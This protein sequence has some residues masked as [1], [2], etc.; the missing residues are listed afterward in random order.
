M[1]V[2]QRDATSHQVTLSSEMQKA[3]TSSVISRLYTACQEQSLQ[4]DKGI[5]GFLPLMKG[6]EAQSSH[7]LA[8][9]CID[10]LLLPPCLSPVEPSF[11]LVPNHEPVLISVSGNDKIQ[12]QPPVHVQP[13][14]TEKPGSL[15]CPLSAITVPSGEQGEKISASHSITTETSSK[16]RKMIK[17]L[18]CEEEASTGDSLFSPKRK[19]RR[20]C[21]PRAGA[22]SQ[23]AHREGTKNQ[24]NLSGCSVSLSSNNVLAK[25]RQMAF[26]SSNKLE[27]STIT[28]CQSK[29]TRR[30]WDL[31]TDKTRIRTPD[32]LNKIKEN[33]SNTNREHSSLLKPVV[34]TAKIAPQGRSTPKQK[35]GHPLKTVLIDDTI[36]EKNG[37]RGTSEQQIINILSKEERKGEKKRCGKRRRN[38]NEG[39]VIAVKKTLT[40]AMDDK[41][42]IIPAVGKTDTP[43]QAQAVNRIR[44]QHSKTRKST[45]ESSRDLQSQEKSGDVIKEADKHLTEPQKSDGFSESHTIFKVTVDRN[46]NQILK[47]ITA[48]VSKSHLGNTKSSAVEDAS[49]CGDEQQMPFSHDASG[50]EEAN[51]AAK[52]EQHPQNPDE[53]KVLVALEC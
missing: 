26:R 38:K 11:N 33:Q 44:H 6:N 34:R 46:H 21:H 1:S 45:T 5:L 20:L 41:S 51:L 15:L 37:D 29:R 13:W 27:S 10:D 24:I 42:D 14:L 3:P 19:M 17:P 48:E 31:C 52:S 8:V 16:N 9:P 35:L 43:T 28:E 40:A 23:L 22:T 53:G 30:V 39:E 12:S 2:E 4:E 36:S 49:V 7:S 18:R 47:D 25:E 32:F 50:E